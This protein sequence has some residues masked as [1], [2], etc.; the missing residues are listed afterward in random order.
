M[1]FSL[2][3]PLRTLFGAV[4][5]NYPQY[6]DHLAQAHK[7]A[8]RA[9]K[10]LDRASPYI[11]KAASYASIATEQAAR[12]KLDEL[13]P[14]L[15]GLALCFF[16]GSYTML[17]AVVETVHLLCWEDLKHSFQVLYHNYERA[18]EQNRKDHCIDA[19]G[20][21]VTDAQEVCDTDLLSRKAALFL[22]SVDIEAAE[23]AGRTI[24]AAAMSVIAAL[25][26][27]LAR[28][29]ALG[30]SLASMAMAY[31]PLEATLKDALPVEHKKWSGVI[32]KTAANVIAMTLASMMC[33]AIGMMHCCIRGAHMFVQHAVHIANGHGL[34]E[35]DI[36]LES[37]KAKALAAM[38][39]SMGLL[40]Q[41]THTDANPFPINI[42]LLPFTVAEYVLFFVV[43]GFLFA[44]L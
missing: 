12:F 37:P 26:V 22:K 30:G 31:I 16:G 10:E 25:R 4:E 40:W 32:A 21:C 7:M 23:A 18:A 6:H 27:K 38:V 5:K 19:D 1:S 13:G 2:E 29:L 11:A 41:V 36:T 39:A 33:G 44:T 9:F 3:S 42:F 24:G 17:I 20:E 15:L 34:L 14:M 35:A 28:S 8:H 43:N